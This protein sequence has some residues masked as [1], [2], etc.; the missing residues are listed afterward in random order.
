[1]KIA[2]FWE[3]QNPEK[4]GQKLANISKFVANFANLVKTATISAN[5]NE[6]LRLE[7]G[8]KECSV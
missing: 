7:N 4:I 3:N 6:T 1:V 8:A 5:L 2:T